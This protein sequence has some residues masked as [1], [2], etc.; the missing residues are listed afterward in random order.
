MANSNTSI[1]VQGTG[2]GPLPLECQHFHNEAEDGT[3]EAVTFCSNADDDVRVPGRVVSTSALPP[4]ALTDP[5]A[6][7]DSC[8]VASIAAPAWRFSDFQT[9][10]AGNGSLH[11]N[12]ELA[13]TDAPSGYP[14]VVA[15]E[16][17]SANETGSQRCVFQPSDGWLGPSNCT[18]KFDAAAKVLTLDAEWKC[19]DL[20]AAHP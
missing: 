3:P 5:R 13:T 10:T 6:I 1:S 12:V 19:S 2:S 17:W 16:R 14:M 4:Y 15:V 18:F 8:T 9:S 11:F 7:T 20:D